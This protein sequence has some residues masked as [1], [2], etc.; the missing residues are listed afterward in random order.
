[1]YN[2]PTRPHKVEEGKALVFLM[3]EYR[4]MNERGADRNTIASWIEEI[5]DISR[6]MQDSGVPVSCKTILGFATLGGK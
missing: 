5:A 1:M 3:Q 4:D 6:V 2:G